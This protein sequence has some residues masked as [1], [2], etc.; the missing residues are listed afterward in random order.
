M[1]WVFPEYGGRAAVRFGAFKL[2]CREVSEN[3]VV[4]VPIPGVNTP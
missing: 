2:L 4:P 1:L 3:P